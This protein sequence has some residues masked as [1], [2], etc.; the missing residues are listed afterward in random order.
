M[1][2]TAKRG[3]CF[4]ID[5]TFEENAEVDRLVGAFPYVTVPEKTEKQ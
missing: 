5:F 4:L 3:Y 2:S 1:F